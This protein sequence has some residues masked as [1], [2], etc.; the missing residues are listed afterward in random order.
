MDSDIETVNLVTAYVNEVRTSKDKHIYYKMPVGHKPVK[1]QVD[2]K[3]TA[4]L[5]PKSNI[6][7]SHI[8]PSKITLI[9]WNTEKMRALGTAKLEVINSKSPTKYLIKFVNVK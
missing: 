5:N 8:K 4:N 9:M 7:N 6:E 1:L 3:A 2:C